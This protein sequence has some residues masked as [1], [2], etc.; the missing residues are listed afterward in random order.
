MPIHDWSKVDA[1]LFHDF[2]QAWTIG[3]RNALNGG[4]LP[5]GY[6]A[7]VEQR[8]GGIVPDVLAIEHEVTLNRPSR[9]KGGVATASR[10]QKTRQLIYATKPILAA[11]GNRIAIHH[12]L[13][14]VVCVIEVVSPGNKSNRVALTKFVNKSVALLE[15]G[16]HLLVVDLFPPS[17]RDPQGIHKAVW[18]EIEECDFKLPSGQRLTLASYVAGDALADLTTAACVETVG[19]GEK[20]PDM[21]AYLDHDTS[22]DVPLESSYMA[23][24]ATCPEAMRVFVEKAQ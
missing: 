2:H 1:N 10:S 19:V 13:G 6:S 16:V 24:W 5:K 17:K 9:S 18:D 11:R 7:L 3:I 14:D 20:M 15:Q 8:T 4:I 12:R 21:P 22:V 23:T